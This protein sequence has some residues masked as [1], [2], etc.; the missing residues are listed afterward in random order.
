[1]SYNK[2]IAGQM[3]NAEF[4]VAGFGSSRQAGTNLFMKT[5]NQQAGTFLLKFQILSQNLEELRRRNL[6]WLEMVV[7]GMKIEERAYQSTLMRP[8]ISNMQDLLRD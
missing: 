4:S 6:F 3:N 7:Q 5:E 1:M 8:L 2:R